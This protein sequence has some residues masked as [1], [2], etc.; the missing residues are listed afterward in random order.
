MPIKLAMLS[1][2]DCPAYS[3][4]EDPALSWVWHKAKNEQPL[5][6]KHSVSAVSTRK[7]II[8]SRGECILREVGDKLRHMVCW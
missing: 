6:P 8:Y 7:E 4:C 3:H 5:P 2:Q 1:T